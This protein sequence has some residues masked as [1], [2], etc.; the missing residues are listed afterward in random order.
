MSGSKN[1]NLGTSRVLSLNFAIG[2]NL[3]LRKRKKKTTVSKNHSKKHDSQ[4]GFGS[5]SV[6]L[7]LM[8]LC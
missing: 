5:M 1:K 2:F 8:F 6:F 7:K 3:I 4:Q